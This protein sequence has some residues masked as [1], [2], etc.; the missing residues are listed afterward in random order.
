MIWYGKVRKKKI[1]T[2]RC[3][4]EEKYAIICYATEDEARKAIEGI[5]NKE[6]WTAARFKIKWGIKNQENKKDNKGNRINSRTTG[7]LER[8]CFACNSKDMK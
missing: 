2:D 4:L 5:K 3:G 7:K 8:Q 1:K 6:G